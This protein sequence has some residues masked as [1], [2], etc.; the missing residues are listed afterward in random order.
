MKIY[1]IFGII[2][3][4]NLVFDWNFQQYNSKKKLKLVG[5]SNV[6]YFKW[7]IIFK[8]CSKNIPLPFFYPPFNHEKP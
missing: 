3:A 7:E 6:G 2:V 8:N 1:C 5:N 4:L